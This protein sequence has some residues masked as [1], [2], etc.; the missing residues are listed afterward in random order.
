MNYK[1]AQMEIMG[2]AIV[3]VLLV[4]GMLFMVKFVLFKEPQ[5]YREDYTNTQLAA[6]MLNSILN[7]NTDCYGI[8]VDELLQ[9]AS[10]ALPDIQCPDVTNQTEYLEK[11]IGE[12]I[13]NQTLKTW[14]KTFFF[15]ASVPSQVVVSIGREYSNKIRERKAHFLTTDVGTMTIILDIYS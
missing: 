14:K 6:N 9:D 7:T 12:K 15:R 10:K 11:T 4:L 5:T 13:L 2:L 1:K 3:V 8:P